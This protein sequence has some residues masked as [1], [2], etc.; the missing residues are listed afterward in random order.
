[1][2]FKIS[3]QNTGVKKFLK[4]METGRAQTFTEGEFGNAKMSLELFPSFDGPATAQ[5][6]MIK[7]VAGKIIPVR[8]KFGNGPT[9]VIYDLMTHRIV[10]AGTLEAHSTLAGKDVPFAVQLRVKRKPSLTAKMTIEPQLN[11]KSIRFVHKFVQM[12]RALWE[13]GQVE[14]FN[15][16][17][18]AVSF[19]GRLSIPNA[20]NADIW[21]GRLVDDVTTIADF[22]R[23]DLKWHRNITKGDID[24]LVMLK[25]MVE[26]KPYGK[27]VQFT[28]IVTKTNENT[29]L[30]TS[31]KAGGSICVTRGEPLVFLG[32][33]I[34]GYTVAYCFEQTKIVDFETVKE[35]FE[36]AV[37]GDQTEVRYEAQGDIWIKLWDIKKNQPVERPN[38]SEIATS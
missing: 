27:G 24:L 34:E 22:L 3:L 7:P 28:G 1:V 33:A 17:S 2:K 18:G 35:R 26:N 4:A 5:K 10:R 32:A 20:S 30:F 14:V 25:T 13:S 15:L 11:G 8:V 37:V 38:Q 9:A 21:F 19:T 23:V 12:K 29:D 16:E 6:L 31:W 36:R